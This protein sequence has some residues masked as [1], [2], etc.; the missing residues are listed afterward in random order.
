M[1]IETNN[2]FFSYNGQ[3]FILKGINLRVAKG[4]IV[5][6]M[7]ENGA[8]KTTLIKHFNGLLKPSRGEVKVLGKDT[9]NESVASLSRHVGMIFQNPDHQLFGETVEK[10]VEF[11]LRNFGFK[12]EVVRK[13]VKWALELMELSEYKDRSPYTLSVGE[14]K[15]LTIASVLAYDPDIVVMDE[16]T[17]GQDAIQK[18]KISEIISLLKHRGKTVI[19][20]THDVEFIVNRIDRVLLMADGR[21]I[22]EGD[23][24]DIL[25][26]LELL[27]K[28]R[29]LPPQIPHIAWLLRKEGVLNEH[30]VLYIDELI[31]AIT[32]QKGT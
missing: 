18:E 30:K 26:N 7:G 14:R 27:E 16:P 10:E 5:A 31:K 17:A 21:I 29:L 12:E 32:S 25:T 19:I 11:A 8:G 2:L 22:A 24:R 6:I 15:R 1:A 20:V 13:R 9:K 4:E 23:K 28:V 3:D